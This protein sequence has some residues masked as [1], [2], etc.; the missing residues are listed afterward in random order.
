MNLEFNQIDVEEPIENIFL[1]EARI[2]VAFNLD[3]PVPIVLPTNIYKCNYESNRMLIYQT[4]PEVLPGYKYQ[5]MH[6]ATLVEKELSRMMRIG[7]KCRIVKF[8]NN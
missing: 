1:H 2:E 3:N 6:I 4:R 8:L 5:S 7:L